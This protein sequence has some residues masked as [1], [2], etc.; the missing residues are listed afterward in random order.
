MINNVDVKIEGGYDIELPKLVPIQQK[1]KAHKLENIPMAVD[2][3]FSKEAVKKSI[4]PGSR[5]AIA[6]GSRGIVNLEEI[7]KQTVLNLKKLGAKPIIIPA[8]GSH[9]GATAEGQIKVIKEYGITEERIGAPIVSSMETVKIAE[10]EHGVPVYFDKNAYQ[11]DGIIVINRIK[12]HTD[13]KGSFESGLMKM[14]VIGL[15]KHKGASYIHNM[16]FKQ[17]NTIIPEVGKQ[18]LKK[19]NI[20]FGM[21]ILENACDETARLEAVPADTLFIREPE[22]L[23]EAKSYMG[24]LIPR[25]FDVLLIEQIGKD[26]SGAGMDPNIV[27]RPGSGLP[28][29]DG[30]SFQKLVV[31]DLTEKTKGNACGI[32]MADITTKSLVEKIDFTYLYTNSITSTVLDP[33][34]LPIA[35]NTEKEALV[36]ALWT[37]NMVK[38]PD[39]KVV[40]IKNTLELSKIL[41]SEPLLNDIKD[42]DIEVLGKEQAILFDANGRLQL[43][44]SQL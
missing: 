43:R 41:V 1:F 11:S 14:L 31:L 9:G 4:K 5:I 39:A 44:P 13:F 26:I 33:A 18:I 29:F 36:I 7:V 6:V 2:L 42:K 19:T 12:P 20:L 30:P 28:G 34:K 23:K 21:A 24:Y 3:E 35:M 37:S 10:T 32:G 8:M 16:G 25:N 38:I 17:F 15:G 40:F 22:L 27:G